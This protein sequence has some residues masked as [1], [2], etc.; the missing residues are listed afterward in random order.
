MYREGSLEEISDGRL[1]ELN[2]MAK[3][4]CDDCKDCSACC[5]GMGNTVLLDP[6]DVRELKKALNMSFEELLKEY[7]ELNIVEG[8]ILPNIRMGDGKCPFLNEMGR[9]SI[10]SSRPGVCRLFPLGRYYEDGKFKY[11]LQTNQCKKDKRTKVKIE[12]WIGIDNIKEYEEFVLKWHY[13]VKDK[14]NEIKE[15]GDTSFARE[16]NMKLLNDFFVNDNLE[17]I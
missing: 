9:C 11:I 10:H 13:Y 12:K 1:Y 14:S 3:L 4:G 16:V 8:V 15:K 7:L 6:W 5:K 2:D 17:A